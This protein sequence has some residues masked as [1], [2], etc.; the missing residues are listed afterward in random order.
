[1][2]TC[3]NCGKQIEDG[4]KPMLYRERVVCSPCY[5]AY[6]P[7]PIVV[8]EKP[9]VKII[10]PEEVYVRPKCQLCGCLME[11]T[12]HGKSGFGVFILGLL[13]LI[14]LSVIE[15]VLG[16]L[17]GG[18]LIIVSLVRACGKK[19]VLKCSGCGALVPCA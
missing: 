17:I 3:E 14:F 11:R 10:K 8:V 6:V 16:I 19:P 5:R 13:V 2:L 7:Q 15:P 12:T 4:D 18:T 9:K 1:M